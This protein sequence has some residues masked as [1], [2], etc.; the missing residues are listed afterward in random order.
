MN[1]IEDRCMNKRIFVAS[2][3]A[4]MVFASGCTTTSGGSSDP[5]ARR[6]SIDTTVDA[7]LG[8]LYRQVPGS[9]DLVGRAQGVLVFP[10][11]LEAG[12]IVGA[13]RGDGA[14]RVGGKTVSYHA[15]TSGSFGLQAGAQSTAMFLL[16]MTKDA[17]ANFQNSR[18][19]TVGAD[20]SVTLL[21]V[22]ASAQMTS[23]TAQQPVIGY[24][25][26]NRGLMAGISIDGARVTTLNLR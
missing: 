11:V 19:W 23:A 15:T 26:S 21:T 2:L 24:V 16:F 12:F 22:G 3:A 14:L 10:S 5:A 20:A 18:G 1:E 9:R 4:L 7:A 17:L 6:N 8:E 13:S 25:L